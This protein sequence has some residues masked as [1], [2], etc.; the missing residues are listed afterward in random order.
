M[1]VHTYM[2]A[3]KPLNDDPR[4][5]LYNTAMA[6]IG[7]MGAAIAGIEPERTPRRHNSPRQGEGARRRSGSPRVAQNNTR[8]GDARNNINQ[9]RMERSREDRDTREYNDEEMCRVSFFTRRVRKTRVPAN[10]KL[11]DHFKKFD[12]LQDPEDWLVDYLE[13]VKLLGGNRATAMQSIQLHLSGVARSWL[14][15]LPDDS[16]DN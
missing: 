1:A 12:G 13:T 9:S 11:P 15:K 2:M 5:A 16:I 3:T 7:I 6:G 4:A 10:F 14:K 8:T